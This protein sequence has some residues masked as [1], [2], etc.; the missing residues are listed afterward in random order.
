MEGV[1]LS[2]D[3]KRAKKGCS[4]VGTTVFTADDDDII[5]ISLVDDT[6]LVSS[7]K[8]TLYLEGNLLDSL[9]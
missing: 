2:L 7:M 5:V 4:R 8:F 1:T 3:T 6:N 9:C